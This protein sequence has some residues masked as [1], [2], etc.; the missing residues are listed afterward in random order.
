MLL[1]DISATQTP[2]KSPPPRVLRLL[3]C[4]QCGDPYESTAPNAKY[5]CDKCR[6]EANG[7]GAGRPAVKTKAKAIAAAVA[8]GV[9]PETLPMHLRWTGQA[10][11]PH[12]PPLTEDSD[13]ANQFLTDFRGTFD[14]IK[15]AQLTDGRP[16]TSGAF[17]TLYKKS[18][19][20]GTGFAKRWDE[21]LAEAASEVMTA[22]R[23]EAVIGV[24]KFAVSMGER[25]SIGKVRDTKLLAMVAKSVDKEFAKA[26]S[27]AGTNVQVNI[28]NGAT[29]NPD[30]PNNPSFTFYLTET[31]RLTDAERQQL[32]Q[33]ASKILS[34]R[35]QQP[36][37]IDL[38]PDAE[39]KHLLQAPIDITPNDEDDLHDI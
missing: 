37:T 35:M 38:E 12:L 33:I 2:K 28:Q 26:N 11:I 18:K 24:D 3:A 13:R 8:S 1:T 27:A 20:L 16:G 21:V 39:T 5:C 7:G 17:R 19:L 15:A 10:G 23:E 31:Y 34:F 29:P 6:H 4:V 22:V 9:N 36:V 14:V 30:D 32:Q 25:V